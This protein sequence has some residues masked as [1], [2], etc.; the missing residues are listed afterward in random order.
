MEIVREKLSHD[1]SDS[2]E[3]ASEISRLVIAQ[4]DWIRI[5]RPTTYNGYRTYRRAKDRIARLLDKPD[6][7]PDFF[8]EKANG[9]GVA[10]GTIILGALTEHPDTEVGV[11]EGNNLDYWA[12]LE[13]IND[14]DA[15]RQITEFLVHDGS[16]TGVKRE[17][18]KDKF[19][20]RETVITYPA[21]FATVQ[22]DTFNPP[23]G[24]M[25]Q[26]PS[27]SVDYRLVALGGIAHLM[28]PEGYTD[29]YGI[30]ASSELTQLYFKPG[31]TERDI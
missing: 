25:N 4:E 28:V 12:G 5:H 22:K 16:V 14:I 18:G 11:V 6:I 15:H 8:R 23:V 26:I 30:A 29:T 19:D 24:L 10:L 20:R 13:L 7:L 27:L 31:H 3:Q 9:R 1:K 21:L 2:K 17:Y